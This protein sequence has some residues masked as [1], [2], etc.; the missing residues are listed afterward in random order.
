MAINTKTYT[1]STLWSMIQNHAITYP[2]PTNLNYF[3][4]FGFL[5]A[6]CLIIQIVSGIFLAMYYT[7]H[8]AYAFDSVEYIMRTV[9]H[10]WLLRHTHAN[11][12][13]MFFIVIYC[14]IG[15]NLYYRSYIYPRQTLWLSGLI[16]FVLLMATAF[17]GYV[18]PWGQMGYWGAT[19]ITNFFSV[20]PFIGVKIAYWLWGGFT[21]DNATLNRFFVLHFLLPFIIVAFTLL[22]IMLLHKAGSNNPLGID[23]HDNITFYPY[24]AVKDL[25][26]FLL[27]LHIFG[28][29]IFFNPNLLGHPDNYI[30]A[31]PLCTPP[32][33]VP[34][35]YFL[36]FYA[37]LRAVPN[38]AG[39]IVLMAASIL[40]LFLLPTLDEA[41]PI[42]SPLFRPEF[43]I[44][45]WVFISVA[46]LLALLGTQPVA[47]PF[48]IISVSATIFYFFY[49]LI[50]LPLLGY[51]EKTVLFNI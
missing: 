36:P 34:E 22:H 7:P 16:L 8:I 26:S 24:Y 38:K 14:H 25:F 30:R 18:L 3:W 4:G 17:L 44:M 9:N 45:F 50:W 39:G 29:L 33:I 12:A 28:Y 41:S 6:M 1:K 47:E 15:R 49:F 40:V 20:I 19:V 46:L 32:H 11:G 43:R 37:I 27:M 10:G 21:V 23:S 42:R 31:N 35:W 2:T 5:S 51:Y 13:S 48:T